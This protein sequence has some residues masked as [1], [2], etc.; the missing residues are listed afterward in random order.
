MI[1][2]ISGKDVDFNVDQACYDLALIYSQTKLQK[3]ISSNRFSNSLAPQEI[4]EMEYLSDTFYSA[5]GYFGLMPEETIK[6]LV[7]GKP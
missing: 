1:L 2:N 6:E 5:L 3:A 7:E 4:E